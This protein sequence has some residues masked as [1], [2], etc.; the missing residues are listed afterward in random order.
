MKTYEVV[1]L[2]GVGPVALGMSRS[3]VREAMGGFCPQFPKGTPPPRSQRTLGTTMPFRSSTAQVMQP[4]SLSSSRVE[5]SRSSVRASTCSTRQHNQSS[6]ASNGWLR[7]TPRTPSMAIRSCSLRLS[8][9]SGAPQ[10]RTLRV[11]TSPQSALGRAATS[12][13]QP[14]YALKRTVREEVSGAIMRCGPA[15][16]LSLGVRPQNPY[17]HP[18]R[19]PSRPT[20]LPCHPASLPS[21]PARLSCPPAGLSSQPAGLFCPPARSSSPPAGVSCPPA[22]LSSSPTGLSCS[23][24]CLSSPPIWLSC[25]PACLSSPPTALSCPPACL[26]GPPYRVILSACLLV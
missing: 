2:Q 23:P 12:A 6:R 15:R 1:P 26:S 4:Q 5:A 25:S 18:V 11:T 10:S 24:A 21:P 14:N 13:V 19:L 3:Q 17:L 8:C 22:C 9:R 20:R 7:S 16:P